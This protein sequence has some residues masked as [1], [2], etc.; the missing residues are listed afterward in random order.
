M[1]QVRFWDGQ[2]CLNDGRHPLPE[3]SQ[4]RVREAAI[5]VSRR[6]GISPDGPRL[7]GS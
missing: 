7:N 5:A 4:G 2:V 6:L 3:G 1:F